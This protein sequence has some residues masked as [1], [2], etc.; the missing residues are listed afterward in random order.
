MFLIIFLFQSFQHAAEAS[1]V[2]GA[3]LMI[4]TA[5]CWAVHLEKSIHEVAGLS[6]ALGP[7]GSRLL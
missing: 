3:V 5:K 2:A 7:L 6:K 1:L 4:G